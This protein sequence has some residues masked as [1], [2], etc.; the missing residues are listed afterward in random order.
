MFQDKNILLGIGGGIAVYRMAELA[1]LLIKQGANVRCVMTQSACEFVT[2]LTFEALTGEAVHTDL[3]DLTSERAMGHIELARWADAVLIAPATSNLLAK[4]AHGIADDLLTTMMQVC[5]APVL[6]APAMNSSM[7]ESAAT[8]RNLHTLKDDGFSVIDPRSGALA[9]GEQ[10][11]GRLPE[12][13]ALADAILP[14]L[15]PQSLQGQHWVIN[16]GPTIEPWDAVRVLTNRA[17]GTL[18]ARLAQ[19]ASAMGASVTLIAGVGTP[20]L[21]CD[22]Q[23]VD[24]QTGDEM[25]QACVQVAQGADV[26]IGTAAVSDFRF[27]EVSE[28]KIKRGDTQQ[29]NV[30]LAANTDIVASIAGME[31][32]PKKV[33]AFAAESE[34]H[35]EYAKAKLERKGVDAIVANDVNN[36]DSDS[37]SGW[38]ID[39]R[40]NGINEE[41]IEKCNKMQFSQEIIKKVMELK[42]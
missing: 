29:L 41:S 13:Q 1:R 15:L 16:A 36:M 38:W 4:L 39:N 9:C 32:R 23:R 7:W 22:V 37:A 26:F 11:I 20:N 33:I 18:G 34:K 25:L 31:H 6:L 10:G 12:P 27:S 5:D 35:I 42:P 28:Q 21:G 2:P 17:S 30:Q 24:V 40:E 19:Y 8:Q 14:L 3:F